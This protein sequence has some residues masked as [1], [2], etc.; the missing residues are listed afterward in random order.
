MG[1]VLI[2]NIEKDKEKTLEDYLTTQ[3]LDADVLK[4]IQMKNQSE[5]NILLKHNINSKKNYDLSSSDDEIDDSNIDYNIDY[6]NDNDTS[7]LFDDILKHQ[8]WLQS[9]SAVSGKDEQEEEVE[10][11]NN[12]ILDFEKLFS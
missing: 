10:E 2:T 7:D 6:D 12:V 11:I 9:V 5:N 1:A 3:H 8:K 4:L